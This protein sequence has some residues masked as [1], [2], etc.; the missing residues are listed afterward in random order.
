MFLCLASLVAALDEDKWL[1][2]S[3]P[4]LNKQ[5]SYD[6]HRAI[7]ELYKQLTTLKHQMDDAF[8]LFLYIL[9]TGFPVHRETRSRATDI[10]LWIIIGI[11]LYRL[12]ADIS[13]VTVRPK[14]FRQH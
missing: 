13:D 10:K 6:L 4:F 2:L 14:A 9:L 8:S 11:A 5:G 1:R 7:K 3:V 12:L